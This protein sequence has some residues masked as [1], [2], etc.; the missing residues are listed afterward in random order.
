MMGELDE[1]VM[2]YKQEHLNEYYEKLDDRQKI[3]FLHQLKEFNWSY[4]ELLHEDKRVMKRGEFSPI[5]AL[6]VDEINRNNNEY[7]EI[8]MKAVKDGEIG[9]VLLAGGQGSRLGYEGP[10]GTLN[11]GKSKDIYIFEILVKQLKKVVI[12]TQTWIHLF[13]MTSE[14]NNQHTIQFFERHNYFGYDKG[15]IHF[16]IQ[17]MLPA[18]DLSGKLLMADM[19]RLA[20]SPNGNGG[21]FSSLV[22]SDLFELILLK[23]IKWLNVISVDNVL[24]K[25]ADLTFIGATLSVKATC[26]AKVIRKNSPTEKVGVLCYEDN[27]PSI[28]EYYDMSEKMANLKDGNG[29]LVYCY[30]VILNYLFSVENLLK[31]Q[32]ERLP[33]HLAKK[34]VEYIKSNGEREKPMQ[35]NAYKFEYLVLDMIRYMDKCLPYEVIREKEFAPIKNMRGIDSLESAQNLLELN[36]FDL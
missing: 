11:V 36:G 19:D 23:D 9:V 7:I 4:L 24:Q 22:N 26:G 17:E 3:S 31:I 20:Y 14:L 28:V 16:Y 13:V 29:N 25:V 33:V 35:E 15:Y 6:T 10:K 2:K 5:K 8:G 30:G 12:E 32:G 21:W 34:K 27:I 1:I 18:V